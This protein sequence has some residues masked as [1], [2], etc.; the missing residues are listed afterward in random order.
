MK[1][2]LFVAKRYFFSRKKKN[3]INVLTV[4][5]MIGVGV[6]TAALII[7]LS[8]FNGLEQLTRDLHTAHNPELKITPKQGKSFPVNDRF[9]KKIKTV[10][11]VAVVTRV[12]EDNALLRYQ[13]AQ[14]AVKIKGVDDSFETQYELKNH[15]REGKLKLKDKEKGIWYALV[16]WGVQSQLSITLLINPSPLVFWYPKRNNEVSIDPGK[17][18]NTAAVT[19]GGVLAIE[20]QFDQNYVLVPIEFAQKLMEYKDHCTALEIRTADPSYIKTA[21][22]E[23]RK[24][25]GEDFFVK[26]ADEQQ[27]TVLRAFKI[28]RLFTIIVFAFILGVASFNIFFS[29]AM[30]VI[31]KQKDIAILYS[32]GSGPRFVRTVFIVLGG[33]IA[34]TGTL[35]GLLIGFIV[36]FVQYKF[37]LVGMGIQSAVVSAY[38]VRPE[39]YDFIFVGLIVFSITVSASLLPAGRAARIGI[40]ENI[41][42]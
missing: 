42:K 6:G 22:K 18:F 3:F 8:V 25:L 13:D 20:Q 14:M 39:L 28:E 12:I 32:L 2:A 33:I 10:K 17:A 29:L 16:G 40:S 27:A 34:L 30:L 7:I 21:Q 4:I 9:L 35:F 11:G 41:S 5:S 38:P 31:E 1:N 15:L 24:I 19:P 23:L 37:E 36:V 26:N